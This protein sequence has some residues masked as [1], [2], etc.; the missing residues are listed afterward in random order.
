MTATEKRVEAVR[1][2]RSREKKNNYTQ[3]RP[4]YVFG[5][6]EGTNPGYGDCSGTVQEILKRAAGI[7]I[8]GNTSAQVDNAKKGKH[9]A[10]IIERPTDNYFDESKLKPGDCLY[11][12]GNKAYT[13]NVGHVEMYT[14]ANECYGH[15]SDMGPKK[16]GG[17][18]SLKSYCAGRTGDRKALMAI[19]WIADDGSEQKTPKL[20]DRA[21]SQG[22][23][24]VVIGDVGELQTL[25]IKLGYNLGTYGPAKNGVDGE[26]GDKTA[27]AVKKEQ[28]H[29]GLLQTGNADLVTIEHIIAHAGGGQAGSTKQYVLVTGGMVNVRKG[30]STSYAILGTVKSGDKYEATGKTSN[31]W[32]EIVYKGSVAW[33]SGKLSEIVK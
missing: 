21:L 4:G 28:S 18:A 7:D 30:T 9:G 25:L 14:G 5:K 22:M 26:Y 33:I 16:N 3:A 13:E 31:G 8:G 20:G 11:F 17:K 29:I 24:T 15:G 1:L 10:V 2:I 6:P 12:K 19:R 27:A 32:Y 23:V